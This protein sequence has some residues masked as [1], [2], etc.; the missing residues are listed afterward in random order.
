[1][2]LNRFTRLNTPT[3]RS[4]SDDRTLREEDNVHPDIQSLEQ[5]NRLL[6]KKICE[7]R[8]RI[9]ELEGHRLPHE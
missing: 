6:R 4:L 2:I 3:V 7:T 1:M 8:R 5:A 9:R